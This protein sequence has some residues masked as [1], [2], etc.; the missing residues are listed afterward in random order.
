MQGLRSYNLPYTPLNR[1]VVQSALCALLWIRLNLCDLIP[2]YHNSGGNV[3]S[4]MLPMC[5]IGPP[6]ITLS[7]TLLIHY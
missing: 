1:M 4:G 6:Y 2:I 7:E 5:T 3:P